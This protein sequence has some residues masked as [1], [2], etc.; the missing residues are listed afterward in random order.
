MERFKE[1]DS[2]AKLDCVCKAYFSETYRRDVSGRLVV[3]NP[4]TENIKQEI[5]RKIL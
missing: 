4:F 3:R 1:C 5:S 2:I